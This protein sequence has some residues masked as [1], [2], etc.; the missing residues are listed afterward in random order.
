MTA[1]PQTLPATAVEIL[2]GQSKARD[3]CESIHAA[4][5]TFDV[6]RGRSL[7]LLRQ[8]HSDLR[9]L[10]DAMGYTLEPKLVAA[11]AAA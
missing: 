4:Y 10:A 8:A 5:W 2:A 3:V 1:V 11:E 7:Y 6:D 9:D